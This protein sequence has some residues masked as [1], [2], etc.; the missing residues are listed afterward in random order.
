MDNIPDRENDRLAA[1]AAYEIMDTPR[2][3]SFDELAELTAKLCDT[4]IAVVN[5]IGDGRQFFKAEV[6]LGVSETPLESS[7]CAKALLEEEFLL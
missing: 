2:E 7:F 5:L 4:P 3:R 1:L 6:G